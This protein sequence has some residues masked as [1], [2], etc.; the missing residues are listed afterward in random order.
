MNESATF[1]FTFFKTVPSTYSWDQGVPADFTGFHDFVTSLSS[2]SAVSTNNDEGI[3]YVGYAPFAFVALSSEPGWP[4]D[5]Q[6]AIRRTVNFGDYYNSES[7]IMTIPHNENVEFCHVYIMPGLYT[8]TF[9]RSEYIQTEIEK[10]V[11]QPLCLQK[12]CIDWSFKSLSN[13]PPEQQITW[14]STRTGGKYQ[15]TWRYEP[16]EE[17]WAQSKALYTQEI[18]KEPKFP[19]SWQWYNFLKESPNPYNEQITWLSSGF[20]T[21]DQLT[22]AETTGPC[23]TMDLTRATTWKWDLISCD[24]NPFHRVITWNDTRKRSPF[25]TT[26]NYTKENCEGSVI[27]LLSTGVQT[28]TKKA[29]VRILEKP[30]IAYLTVKDQPSQ[31]YTP[32]TVTLSPRDT[33]CGSFP[34]EKIVWDLGDGSPLLVQRR[35]SNTLEEPFIFSGAV[36]NDYQDP[37]NYDIIHTYTRSVGSK[38]SFYPS[39][40]AYASSTNSSDSA[41]AVVGPLLLPKSPKRTFTLLQNELTDDGKVFIGQ[42]GDNV[43]LWRAETKVSDV[44]TLNYIYSYASYWSADFNLISGVSKLYVTR[45]SN[46]LPAASLSGGY[47]NPAG[48]PAQFLS[49]DYVDLDRDG[50]LDRWSTDKEGVVSY[51]MVIYYPYAHVGYYSQDKQ[52]TKKQSIIYAGQGSGATAVAEA[53]GF[54]EDID[55]DGN[56]DSWVTDADGV[57]TWETTIFHPYINLTHYYTNVE[58]LTSQADGHQMWDGRYSSASLIANLSGI[59]DVDKDGNLDKWVADRRGY[60]SWTMVLLHSRAKLGYVKGGKLIGVSTSWWADDTINR[61]DI[62]YVML[63]GAKTII[64]PTNGTI[65]NI[66]S[67]GG[68]TKPAL[69]APIID[70]AKPIA[71]YTPDNDLLSEILS[72][73]QNTIYFT[74]ENHVISTILSGAVHA[75]YYTD[76]ET[77]ISDSTTLWNGQGTGA[78]KVVNLSGSGIDLNDDGNDD[79]WRTNNTGI[80]TWYMISAH[81][82]YHFGFYSAHE[83]LTSNTSKLFLG[84]GTG[85][86]PLSL[87]GGVA[88]VDGDGNNDTWSTDLDG[89]ITYAKL[90]IHPRFHFGYYS[91]DITLVSGYSILWDG[92]GSAATRASNLSGIANVLKDGNDY[93]YSTDNIGKITFNKIIAHPYQQLGSYY[94][95]EQPLINGFSVIW[96]GNGTG[97][98]PVPNLAGSA[99]MEGTGTQDLYYTDAFGRISW[100]P[101][102]IHLYPHLGYYG[103][104]PQLVN[105]QSILWDSDERTAGRVVNS[106]GIADVEGDGNNDVWSTSVSGIVTWAMISAHPFDNL[107]YYTDT[108]NITNGVSVLWSGKGTGATVVANITGTYDFNQDGNL[109]AW[110]TN[111]S[112]VVLFATISAHPYYHFGYYSEDE[113]IVSGTSKLWSGRGTGA[114]V[115]ANAS[116]IN[117]VNEDGDDDTWSTDVAGIITWSTIV[118]HPY[119]NVTGYYTDVEGLTSGASVLW[120]SAGTSGV[121]LANSNGVADFEGDGNNDAWTTDANGIVAWAMIS[122]HPYSKLGY[123]TDTQVL[124][125]GASALWS[126]KGTG[127]TLISG[128]SGIADI[129]GDGS[130]ELWSTDANGILTFATISAHPYS[131]LGYYADDEFLIKEYSVLWNDWRTNATVVAN[132]SGIAKIDSDNFNDAWSTDEHGVITWTMIPIIG[133]YWFSSVNTD[134]FALTS[135]YSDAA[136]LSVANTL[137]T[138]ATDV[139]IITGG[140]VPYVAM[141]NSKWVSPRSINAIGTGI[142]FYSKL[143]AGVTSELSGV[144][145]TFLGNARYGIGND[146]N[147]KFWFSSTDTSLNVLSS[148]YRDYN[149]TVKADSLP[150]SSTNIIIISGG[151]VPVVNLDD[152]TWIEPLSIDATGIGVTFYS[153]LSASVKCT[154]FGGP[155]TFTGNSEFGP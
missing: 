70:T 105:G 137:P 61:T 29:S 100:L 44:I 139:T 136:M 135:W 103:D 55:L 128:V 138:S 8:I 80:V 56:E 150:I 116:G 52:L 104:T 4:S 79:I 18:G 50:N 62:K 132:A 147:R 31:P 123:Y 17:E 42:I 149:K 35:W 65:I 76:D 54:G 146:D 67:G 141:D 127:A 78:I 126:D 154:L 1:D 57:I 94:S 58:Y 64:N 131:H 34:I 111:S 39:I 91:D 84:K 3:E 119:S 69:L 77:I 121:I 59:G 125:S 145:I 90:I 71:Y 85:A 144:P 22:W 86:L 19:L 43:S 16:C 75:E 134:W 81:P 155:M 117:D 46:S 32:L 72:N 130:N 38:T 124:T 60:L 63:S 14:G 49:A 153:N 6:L 107:G 40:T 102:Y 20:Q 87:G 11:N 74:S 27:P 12:Y 97:A 109:E 98:V 15:K 5:S 93:T 88:D 28:V 152:P 99:D 51:E 113:T 142:T 25:H 140:L 13:C 122:A 53:S 36:S 83:S 41:A 47:Y 112:G 30:P 26:W 66:L 148:W 7:N 48:L 114:T 110:S 33:I 10:F 101:R 120:S 21:A 108:Q 133:N 106:N 96:N 37:R 23:I 115:I 82:Y 68:P 92:N 2:C 73:S 24:G 129:D 45:Y 9:E 151:L 143:L 118:L 95:N 89:V